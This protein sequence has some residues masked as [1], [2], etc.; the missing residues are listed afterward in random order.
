MA[1][2][3]YSSALAPCIEGLVAAKRACGFSYEQV[4]YNL[5]RI[6]SIVARLFW[7]A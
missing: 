3:S 2:R 1:E 6:D 5:E 7:T 4:A